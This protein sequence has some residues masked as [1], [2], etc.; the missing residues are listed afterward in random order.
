MA[1][2]STGGWDVKSCSSGDG[3]TAL[4]NSSQTVKGSAGK[5]GGWYIYNPNSA[6]SYVIVYDATSPTVGTT[7]PKMVICVPA[8]GGTNVEF[9]N[10]IAFANAIT[11][12]ATTTG[13]G[14]VAPTTALE[15]NFMYK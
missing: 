2:I 9:T 15:A 13:G 4:T 12:A 1:P 7:T 11:V 5:L 8:N 6:I 10:G 14:S 3:L